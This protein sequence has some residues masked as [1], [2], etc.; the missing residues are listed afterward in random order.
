M[1]PL[2]DMCNHL[3]P[4]LTQ[5]KWQYSSEHKGFTITALRQI[6][7]G[8]EINLCYGDKVSNTHWFY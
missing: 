7:E 8:E 1:V 4:G 6:D 2:A 5:T 3:Q